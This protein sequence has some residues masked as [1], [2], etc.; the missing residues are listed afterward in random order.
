MPFLL[1]TDTCIYALKQNPNVLEQLLSKNREEILVSV[2]TEAELRTGA[3]KSSSAIKT[4]RLLENF[5]RPLAV[6]EFTSQDAF[7]Y[8]HVRARLE[9]AGTPIGPLDTL[10]ASQAVARNLTL[11][12]NNE[13]EFR[14]VAGLHVENWA[15]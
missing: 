4:L 5:L 10:I 3:A 11:V 2:I 14:R 1:D 7:A 15:R 6:A 12:S 8:A 13:R 9:R